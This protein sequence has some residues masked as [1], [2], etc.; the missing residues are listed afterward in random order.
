VGSATTKSQAEAVNVLIDDAIFS[1]SPRW[2]ADA[3][4]FSDIGKGTVHR[5]QAEGPSEIVVSDIV[6]PS[7]LGWTKSG[8]L[9]V[10]SLATSTI[11]RVGRDG[12]TVAFAGPE[13]HGSAATNDMATAGS[14]SYIS[15]AGRVFQLGDDEAA[16]SEAVGT[17]LLIDHDSGACRTVATGLK[18]PNGV[19]ITPDGR[20]LVLAELYAQRILHFD[21][22]KDGS[23]SKPRVFAELGHIA[24][25]I[26]LDAEGGLWIG[27]GLDR[28]QRIDA[29]GKPTEVVGVPGWSC[30]APMLGGPDGRTLYI[31]ANLLE[32]PDDIFTGK[33]KGRIVTAKVNVPAAPTAEFA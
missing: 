28:C 18:M 33:S 8:D 5:I 29:T 22:L 4:W 27:T 16:L 31:A 12:K 32:K 14:R 17:V 20:T 6:A 21:I 11:Y 10:A 3:F 25:G 2:H 23:L 1:E 19:A 26:C 15:C 13:Q 9:L 30:V 7:G 24:D